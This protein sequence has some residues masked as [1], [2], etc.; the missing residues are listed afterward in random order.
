M[1]YMVEK[2]ITVESFLL[3]RRSMFK[4]RL[5]EVPE[6]HFRLEKGVSIEVGKFCFV[7]HKFDVAELTC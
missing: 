4:A 1:P 3:V 5:C 7:I 6:K 2:Q